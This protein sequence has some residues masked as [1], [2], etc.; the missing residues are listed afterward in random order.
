[1][2]PSSRAV[3]LA[4]ALLSAAVAARAAVVV[5][6]V[7][8]ASVPLSPTPVVAQLRADLLFLG[9]P[10]ALTLPPSAVTPSPSAWTNMQQVLRAA[11]VALPA[12]A[13]APVAAPA[14]AASPLVK[15][16]AVKRLSVAQEILG[17][18]DPNEFEKL[19]A[20]RKDAAMAEL[21]DGWRSRGLVA[22]PTAP[23]GA[24]G[25][26]RADALLLE[27][28][29]DKALTFSNKS[30]FLGVGVLGYPLEDALWLSHTRITQAID[31][32]RLNYPAGQRWHTKDGTPEFLGT[33]VRA[34]PLV[35]AWA[36]ATD[37][38][39]AVVRQIEK[40]SREL[41]A[42]DLVA[43]AAAAGF[44][45]VAAELERA[46]D[47]EALEYLT[48]R[49]PTFTAFLLDVRKPGYYLYNGDGSVV[50]RIMATGAAKSLGIRRVDHPDKGL[51]D[52]AS[53][54]YYRPARVVE[55]LRDAAR[56]PAPDSAVERSL[57]SSYAERLAP[58]AAP[59][60]EAGI[61]PY[62]FVEPEFLPGSAL[63][64]RANVYAKRA[65]DP[66]RLEL[67]LPLGSLRLR[68]RTGDRSLQFTPERWSALGLILES[69][70][71]LAAA[72]DAVTLRFV[73]E[74]FQ[75][76][77]RKVAPLSGRRGATV[78]TAVLDEVSRLERDDPAG[79]K[80]ELRFLS[81]AFAAALRP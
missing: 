17:R 68:Q 40:R 61:A 23:V 12:S 50:A 3:R 36:A 34:Q 16:D 14:A 26:A 21:W 45:R 32:N 71:E 60:A 42:G 9:T 47:R 10:S 75:S 62:R 1:M 5:E 35:D 55:R 72:D 46:G 39:R 64:S 52:H 67:P 29:D 48:G 65:G 13:A 33:S 28:V 80:R 41:P 11:P 77:Q 30:I 63:D 74:P 7:P 73:G 76:G 27:G 38:G 53:T 15:T 69:C 37:Y 49:D 6:S 51:A 66:E 58:H 25:G 19:P 22:D 54:Y 18:Y 8:L 81:A 43:P 56:E 31:D 4:A 20:D 79:L 44:A 59:V 78:Q 24:D 2:A 57:L 70:P